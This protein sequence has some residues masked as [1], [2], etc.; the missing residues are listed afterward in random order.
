[1]N[2][3][4]EMLKADRERLK[5]SQEQLAKMLDVS[6][7]A[8]ANW[9]AGTSH[10]RRDRRARLM[11]ILGPGAALAKNPPR[12]DFVPAEPARSALRGT[13]IERVL[14]LEEAQT[15]TPE[16][17]TQIQAEQ[18]ARFE[19]TK[20][21]IEVVMAR[22]ERDRKIMLNTL[23]ESLH[24]YL[25]RSIAIGATNRYLDY[26]SPRLGVEIKRTPSN[27]F[28]N[29][30]HMAP[31][32]VHLAVVRN[33]AQALDVKPEYMLIVVNEDGLPSS[34]NAM[35]RLMF[36]AGV[37]GVSVHEVPSMEAAGHLIAQIEAEPPGDSD[38]LMDE[39]ISGPM[40]TGEPD[41]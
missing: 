32:L 25:K 20:R 38:A 14:D 29:W 35:Q 15:K 8:V 34:R 36:D 23:P 33:I 37:L 24:Q 27:K 19:A 5:M 3:F 30:Q 10:P 17:L 12:Y 18:R 40:D 9:E 31:S 39:I 16:E 2:T 22:V 1:M 26:L 13:R 7:Q 11:Q 21:K 4:G 41:E 28:L 6:Q